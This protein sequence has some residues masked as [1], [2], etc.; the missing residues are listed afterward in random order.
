M[1]IETFHI[2][3]T[4]IAEIIADDI[5]LRTTEDGLD[6]LGIYIIKAMIKLSFT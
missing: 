6:L 2:N 5:V 4:K 3:S 1:E